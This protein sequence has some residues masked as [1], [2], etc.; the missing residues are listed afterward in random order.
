M[1]FF[2]PKLLNPDS[3][4]P[5]AINDDDHRFLRGLGKRVWIRQSSMAHWWS[6]HDVFIKGLSC[7]ALPGEHGLGM[8]RFFKVVANKK[9][10]KTWNKTGKKHVF[11]PKLASKLPT[12]KEY[13]KESDLV[14]RKLD[15]KLCYF[16]G[17]Q[18]TVPKRDASFRVTRETAWRIINKHGD[19]KSPGP[20]PSKW[21]FFHI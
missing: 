14:K 13:D 1:C 2:N 18:G 19:R 10:Y 20:V 3:Q 7:S 17:F 8:W 12:L 5:Y 15:L 11:L 6:L 9:W 16:S 4:P 21:P